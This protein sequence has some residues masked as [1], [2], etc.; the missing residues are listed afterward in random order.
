MAASIVAMHDGH[1]RREAASVLDRS[2][3]LIGDAEPS[4]GGYRDIPRGGR[5]ASMGLR[6]MRHR[7]PAV[8]RGD[9][10]PTVPATS[11]ERFARHETQEQQQCDVFMG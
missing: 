3:T 4:W 10:P 2:A 9:F 1:L 8:G 11:R 7:R 6:A 5:R